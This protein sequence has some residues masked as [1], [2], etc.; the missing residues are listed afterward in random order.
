M[1]APLQ[2]MLILGML[3]ATSYYVKRHKWSLLKSRKLV[4]TPKP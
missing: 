1:S 3:G 4:F 2:V